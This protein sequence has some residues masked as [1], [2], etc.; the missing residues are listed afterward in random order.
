MRNEVW[1]KEAWKCRVCVKQY[2]KN[3]LVAGGEGEEVLAKLCGGPSG[4]FKTL[5]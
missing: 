5:C 4:I 1:C 2:R 3:V